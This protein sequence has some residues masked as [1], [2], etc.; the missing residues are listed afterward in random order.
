LTVA[1]NAANTIRSTIVFYTLQ[2]E[3]KWDKVTGMICNM[4]S[5]YEESKAKPYSLLT[6]TSA[7]AP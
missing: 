6:L 4:T 2:F 3:E 5:L 7:F 1:V